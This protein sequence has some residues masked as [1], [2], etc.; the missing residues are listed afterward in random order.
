MARLVRACSENSSEW[1]QNGKPELTFS[2]VKLP[3]FNEYRML[4][5]NGRVYATVLDRSAIRGTIQY[6]S[7]RCEQTGG[8]RD[9]P[10]V[11]ARV[12]L[13]TILREHLEKL[14]PEEWPATQGGT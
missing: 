12:D 9:S 11:S 3:L 14:N 6:L 13:F 1:A 8:Y 4:D 5:E 7:W 10:E 2:A